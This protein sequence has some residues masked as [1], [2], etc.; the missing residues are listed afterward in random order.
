MSNNNEVLERT[1]LSPIEAWKTAHSWGEKNELKDL[2]VDL[3]GNWFGVYDD[4][5]LHMFRKMSIGIPIEE[6]SLNV[7]NWM[8]F[9]DFYENCEKK[10][11]FFD[12]CKK[13]VE[14]EKK[15]FLDGYLE[16]EIFLKNKS[17]LRNFKSNFI[18][19]ALAH[20]S[21]TPS[22]EYK[23]N[24]INM[25]GFLN[26][27]GVGFFLSWQKNTTYLN[28]SRKHTNLYL[29]TVMD[30]FDKNHSKSISMYTIYNKQRI[31]HEI[32]TGMAQKLCG[33]NIYFENWGKVFIDK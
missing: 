3:I 33:G 7:A 29:N 31:Q 5:L 1:I 20:V 23:F 8:I 12:F 9:Q 16:G 11:Y 4:N 25:A 30:Y 19:S 13:Y 32:L 10:E 15:S 22:N 24:P 21:Y 26:A 14:Y 6:N 28:Y 27:Y 17:Y 2:A 18:K